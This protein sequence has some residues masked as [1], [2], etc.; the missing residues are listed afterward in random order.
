M[1]YCPE[2]GTGA[3]DS[4]IFCSECGERFSNK[5]TPINFSSI[6]ANVFSTII[7]TSKK[8]IT[9]IKSDES[10][11]TI[12]K[13]IKNKKIVTVGLA[14]T[15]LLA[16]II[17]GSIIITASY[18]PKKIIKSFQ[19]AII[20]NDVNKLETLYW[21]NHKNLEVNTDSLQ[22]IIDYLNSSTNEFDNTLDDLY[23]D[24]DS[25]K[26]LSYEGSQA[27]LDFDEIFALTIKEK[28][29]F[30]TK[31]G[32]T[33]KPLYFDIS[34][35]YLNSDIYIN[36]KDYS[37]IEDYESS[38]LIGPFL[39]NKF[40]ITLK[41]KN[42]FS[43]DITET[44]NINPTTLEELYYY[45]DYPLEFFTEYST[46]SID[47]NVPEATIFVNGKNTGIQVQDTYDDFGPLNSNDKIYLS[48]NINGTTYKTEEKYA[49]TYYGS[50]TLNFAYS[51]YYKI[52]EYIEKNP[53]AFNNNSISETTDSDSTQISSIA[54]KYIDKYSSR[55]YIILNSDTVELDFKTLNEYTSEELFIARNEILARH[56]Y[57]DS[58]HPNLISYFKSK[59]WY[60]ENSSFIDSELSEVETYNYNLIKSIEFL[61]SSYSTYPSI[62]SDYVFANSDTIELTA[63][64]VSSL[65]N[66]ELIVARNEIY[67]R[68]G[69]HFSTKEL[70]EH[71]KSKS[72]FTIDSSVNNN[73]ELNS[74]EY[75]NVTTIL[76]EENRRME[77]VTN[78]D[79]GE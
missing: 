12:N 28:N 25:I 43:E 73:V 21:S 5:R 49:F 15:A 23:N 16:L 34:S 78:H 8:I 62:S 18:S 10:K 39:P 46:I 64:Q 3:Q 77:N 1:K 65:N 11:E 53:N 76:N 40:T 26:L 38:T 20:N 70:L 61:K 59:S 32:I 47:S 57:I 22:F 42:L 6:T 79:L 72:W 17:I 66:W 56:G 9:K 36:D 52:A 51:D 7:S 24:I 35:N 58:S 48:I 75:K 44:I 55:D 19:N 71:F 27:L 14:L 4:E 37:T 2:C 29:W 63:S 67:A 41:S 69:L 13:I 45:E 54:Q 33:I 30:F 68:Y 50:L 60:Q 74:I 31:Y